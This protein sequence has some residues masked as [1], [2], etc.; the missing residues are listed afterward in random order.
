MIILFIIVLLV[1]H[2]HFLFCSLEYKKQ[3]IAKSFENYRHDYFMLESSRILEDE[4]E[5]IKDRRYL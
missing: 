5:R 4:W 3:T 1:T 2:V